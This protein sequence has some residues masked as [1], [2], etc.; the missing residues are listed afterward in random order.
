MIPANTIARAAKAS[1]KMRAVISPSP[2]AS[3]GR[4]PRT[5]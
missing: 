1:K 4:P 2:S 3:P 5:G